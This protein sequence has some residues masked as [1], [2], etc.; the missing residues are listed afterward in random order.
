MPLGLLIVGI[1]GPLVLK[2]VELVKVIPLV[3]VVSVIAAAKVV[4]TAVYFPGTIENP[5]AP[6]IVA[7]DIPSRFAIL[8]KP[9]TGVPATGPSSPTVSAVPVPGEVVGGPLN[10]TVAP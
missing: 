10:L 3:V 7:P 9:T 6:Q 5:E 1:Y 8:A 4:V 2:L